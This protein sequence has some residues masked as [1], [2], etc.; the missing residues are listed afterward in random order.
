MIDK[1]SIY[2][3]DNLIPY[4]NLAMEEFLTF[5]VEPG[6]CILFLWQ[7]RQT[8]V[9]GKN[10]NCWK[11][12]KVNYLEED[13]GY[14]VRRLSGGGAVFHDL[15][16]L[17]FTFCVRKEDYD[18]EKQQE[19]IIQAVR[20]LGLDA[21]KTGRN[22]ITVDGRKFSGNAFYKSRGFC[23]HHGTLLLDTDRE[24]MAKYLNVSKE[25][26][27][28]KSVDSVR[29]RVVNL[30]E[31]NPEITVSLMEEKLKQSFGDVYGC[32]V[33]PLDESRLDWE[34]IKE[35]EERFASWEWKYGRKIPFQY[36]ASRRFSWGDLELQFQV[37]EGVVQA[38]NAFS[39]GMDQ[40]LIAK[41]P[42][43]WEGCRYTQTDLLES[44]DRLPGESEQE[45]AMKTDIGLLLQEIL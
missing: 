10:Q 33:Q 26:L 42:S 43:A 3:T 29:S 11:E 27:Q 35:K 8:V 1:L 30:K 14:L 24:K 15:G 40:E 37:D 13:G 6:E 23:Y 38:V 16:N 34:D 41:L 45:Q 7:N 18:V 9:I 12:C 21:R 20:Y 2:I 36:S 32:E 25:K 28:S 31:L 4:K 17:N 22:D 19:V 44:L 39:D 5:C